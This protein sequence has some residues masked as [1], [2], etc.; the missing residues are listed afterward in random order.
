M[1]NREKYHDYTP[2]ALFPQLTDTEGQPFL[3]AGPCSAETREQLLTTAR[4]LHNQGVQVL[5]AGLWK[6]RTYPGEFEGVGAEALPWLV[7]AR[8]ETGMLIGTEVGTA[9]H[10]ESALAAELD[11]L[12]IGARTT[13]SPFAIYEIAEALKG[14]DIPVLVKNPLNPSIDLWKG[15]VYRLLEA[16]VKRV[17]LIHRGFDIG[18]PQSLRNTPLW[19]VAQE[20]RDELPHL[21]IYLDPSHIAGRR[22]YLRNLIQIAYLLQYDGLMIESHHKP[23]EAWSDREQQI[24]PAALAFTLATLSDTTEPEQLHLLRDDLASIDERLLLLLTHRRQLTRK[25]GELKRAHHIAPF[26]EEQYQAKLK[27]ITKSAEHYQLPEKLI[28]H[29]Y[30]IIHDDSVALQEE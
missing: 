22:D 16:G 7:E 11:Y 3:I 17:G 26:Q 9:K 13:A 8:E 15:A 30:S 6:P 20:M 2:G 5:R 4:Q 23:D 19:S 24:T 10:A 21:P 14:S 12:W 27:A 18:V 28:Q 1:S 25:I 29:L